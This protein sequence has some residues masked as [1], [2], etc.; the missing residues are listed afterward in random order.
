MKINANLVVILVYSLFFK[1]H[2]L[3]KDTIF[4]PIIVRFIFCPQN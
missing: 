2:P 4:V 3:I 1:T